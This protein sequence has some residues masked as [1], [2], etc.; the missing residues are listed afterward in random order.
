MGQGLGA[1][2]ALDAREAQ[3][4]ARGRPSVMPWTPNR[5]PARPLENPGLTGLA[6]YAR[7]FGQAASGRTGRF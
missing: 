5:A 7:F 4:V 6:E 2:D 1:V 3:T